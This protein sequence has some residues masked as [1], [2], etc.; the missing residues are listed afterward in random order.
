MYREQ[1][2]SAK[3]SIGVTSWKVKAINAYPVINIEADT[4]SVGGREHSD[5]YTLGVNLGEFGASISR[6]TNFIPR[7]GSSH[8]VPLSTYLWNIKLPV[9]VAYL[10]SS[11]CGE[12][13]PRLSAGAVLNV[14]GSIQYQPSEGISSNSGLYAYITYFFRTGTGSD[15]G[16]KALK[17]TQSPGSQMVNDRNPNINE[18]KVLRDKEKDSKH[19]KD[20]NLNSD[21][22]DKN[23]PALEKAKPAADTK[24]GTK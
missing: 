5:R 14:G 20:K 22:T 16:K 6:A 4:S 11:H 1:N 12:K 21:W 23:V 18:Q 24:E 13:E 19:V 9:D 7:D 3:L 17:A 8:L 10:V 15:R 2:R